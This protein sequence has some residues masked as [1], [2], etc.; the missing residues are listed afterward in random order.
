[1]PKFGGIYRPELL[2][3]GDF[4]ATSAAVITSRVRASRRLHRPFSF[5]SEQTPKNSEG[6]R[7]RM[8]KG[9]WEQCISKVPRKR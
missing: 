5:F 9:G 7:V 8:M 3:K 6:E 2:Q 1:L 4:F